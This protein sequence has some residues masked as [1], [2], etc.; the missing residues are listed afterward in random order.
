MGV[1]ISASKVQRTSEVRCTCAPAVP[2]EVLGASHGAHS[3]SE[4]QR[5]QEASL[6]KTSDLPD[7]RGPSLHEA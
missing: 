4:D 2:Q 5:W 3:E 7:A 1:S 6:L